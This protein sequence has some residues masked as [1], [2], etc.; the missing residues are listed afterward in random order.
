MDDLQDEFVGHKAVVKEKIIP[1][2]QGKVEF[3]GTLW[4]ADADIEIKEGNPV[5][6]IQKENITL[7]VKLLK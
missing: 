4:K 7:K 3:N 6:I 1:G 2:L 5:E